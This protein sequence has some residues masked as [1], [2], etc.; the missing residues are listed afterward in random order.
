MHAE[1]GS[2]SIDQTAS[3]VVLKIY[4]ANINAVR[5]QALPFIHYVAICGIGPCYF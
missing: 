3:P 5:L 1:K 2:L 4:G